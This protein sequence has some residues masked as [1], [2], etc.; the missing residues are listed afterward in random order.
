MIYLNSILTAVICFPI[1][2]FFITLPFL[3]YYYRKYGSISFFRGIIFYSFCFYLLCAYFL[4]ILPLPSISSVSNYAGSYYNLKPF[5]FIPDFIT[6]DV[7]DIS[8]VSS[9]LLFFKN[10]RYMEAFFN[11]LLVVPFGVYLRY[12][13]RCGALKTIV[14]SFLLS[15]F[16]ELT[17]LSGLYFIY[18]KPYR[19]FDVNDL[20][21][22]TFGGLV[23]YIV[24]PLFY[25]FLPS[26]SRLDEHDYIK[27]SYVS[28]VRRLCA[29]VIDYFIVI[30][31]SFLMSVFL[32]DF[33]L[34]YFVVNSIYF[35]FVPFIFNGYSIG[36]FFLKYR[37]VCESGVG[38]SFF[39]CFFKWL[40]VHFYI[41]NCWLFIYLCFN[42]GIYND[43]FTLFYLLIFVLFCV[44]VLYCF[45]FK[46][47]IFYDKLFNLNYVS[48]VSCY[49]EV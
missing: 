36:S 42:R 17:Q 6:S 39:A 8:D 34:F 15:L 18:P 40:F 25:F 30:I 11:V 49:E 32:G 12:Y 7:F 5:Y 35:V 48:E 45:L 22:N 31:F 43:Y 23:G 16:F 24:A 13:F 37:C 3:V 44:H 26:R 41:L 38:V 19:L 9:Y 1:L 46:R 27:G 20:I 4:V 47:D 2:S 33:F 29:L 21:N 10:S 28:I 14:L